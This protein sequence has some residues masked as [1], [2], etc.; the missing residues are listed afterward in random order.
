MTAASSLPINTAATTS[1][2]PRRH[3][4]ARPGRARRPSRFPRRVWT[5]LLF[6]GAPG[7]QKTPRRKK[8]REKG[9]TRRKKQKKKEIQAEAGSCSGCCTAPLHSKPRQRICSLRPVPVHTRT[10]GPRVASHTKNV[11]RPPRRQDAKVGKRKQSRVW[12]T[13]W[14][15]ERLGHLRE[16]GQPKVSLQSGAGPLPDILRWALQDALRGYQNRSLHLNATD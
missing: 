16:P 3:V 2:G 13:I 9:K 14:V 1:P 10:R 6:L 4:G 11:R 7:P 12:I 8:Q 5:G 15:R